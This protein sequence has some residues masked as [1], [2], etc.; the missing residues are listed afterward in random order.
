ME[1]TA[2]ACSAHGSMMAEELLEI[3]NGKDNW[4]VMGPLSTHP[5]MYPEVLYGGSEGGGHSNPAVWESAEVGVE[6]WLEGC[7]VSALNPE[8]RTLLPSP[9]VPWW[10][11]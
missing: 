7:R 2:S 1:K 11:I 4:Q 9:C 5:V 10:D 3:N 8:L 6:V